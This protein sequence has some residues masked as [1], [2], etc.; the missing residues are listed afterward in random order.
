MV[1]RSLSHAVQRRRAYASRIAAF[2][3]EAPSP[4]QPVVARDPIA[5][6][7]ESLC[8]RESLWT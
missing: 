6:L 2:W 4:P 7:R 1:R 5:L 3:G 8:S